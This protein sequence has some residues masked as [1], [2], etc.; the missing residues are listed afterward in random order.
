MMDKEAYPQGFRYPAKEPFNL[1]KWQDTA[2]K[3]KM[4][5]R[6]YPE[7]TPD[8][9]LKHFTR[10]WD[11]QEK[12]GF[13]SWWRYMQT[14]QGRQ[15]TIMQKTAYDYNSANKEQELNELKKKL[16]SRIN[17]AEKL[18]NRML[19]EG[20]LGENEEK[21]L[22]IS[23]IIQKLKEEINTLRRPKLMEARHNRAGRILRKAGLDELADIMAGSTKIIASF[24]K[25]P[26][27]KT[28]AE[29]GDLEHA[30][31][32]IKEELD[33]FNFGEHLEKF[34]AIRKELIAA[35]RHSEAGMVVAIIQKELNNVESLHK[36]LVELYSTL[37]S[38][39][40]RREEAPRQEAAPRQPQ[41]PEIQSPEVPAI[42]R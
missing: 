41:Q 18:L 15:E 29:G 37:G 14:K 9:I 30:T 22:Y 4:A 2:L 36:K 23:R 12:E 17:S 28:A 39:P 31:R 8:Q 13:K 35:G 10:E 24:G 25:V 7:Y 16:R 5:A 40:Q 32:L 33:A 21:A 11:F 42:P 34:M 26:F 27:V 38:V 19:D 6:E 3:M 1:K 20:L